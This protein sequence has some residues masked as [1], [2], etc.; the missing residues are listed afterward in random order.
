MESESAP[1]EDKTAVAPGLRREHEGAVAPESHDE[2][3]FVSSAAAG[4]QS[5]EDMMAALRGL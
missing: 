3:Q 5:V 4:E 2:S 1:E